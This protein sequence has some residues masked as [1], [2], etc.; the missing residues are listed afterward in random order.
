MLV[1]WKD[2]VNI[3]SNDLQGAMCS[4]SATVLLLGEIAKDLGSSHRLE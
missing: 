2:C 1:F 4:W 3:C